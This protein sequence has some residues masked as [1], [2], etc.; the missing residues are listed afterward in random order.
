MSNFASS[1]GKDIIPEDQENS[2]IMF[3]PASFSVSGLIYSASGGI[4]L[5]SCGFKSWE[6]I[7]NMKVTKNS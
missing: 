3:R 6:N 4:I 5:C 7:N 1:F 2:P